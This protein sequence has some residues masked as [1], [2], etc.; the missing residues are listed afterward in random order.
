MKIN[1]DKII[2]Y[3]LSCGERGTTATE[4][5]E[6]TGCSRETGCIMINNLPKIDYKSFSFK[7]IHREAP[8]ARGTYMQRKVIVG[9][10][11]EL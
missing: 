1:K 5:A 11:N 7:I 4:M 2:D 10:V 9:R 8:D 6:N 3:I